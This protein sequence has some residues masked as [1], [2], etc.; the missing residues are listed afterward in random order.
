[1]IEKEYS[2]KRGESRIWKYQ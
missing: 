1:M 2:T